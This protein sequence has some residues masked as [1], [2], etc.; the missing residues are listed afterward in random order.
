MPPCSNTEAG[1][2]LRVMCVVPPCKAYLAGKRGGRRFGQRRSE[3]QSGASV[4]TLGRGFVP[5][6]AV[7]RG[8]GVTCRAGGR[9]VARGGSWQLV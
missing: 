7:E 1:P 3:R 6:G 9:V 5:V 4:W 8:G 2:R